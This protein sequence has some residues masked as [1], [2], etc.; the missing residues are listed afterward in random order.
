[1]QKFDRGR[2]IPFQAARRPALEHAVAEDDRRAAETVDAAVFER[3]FREKLE[4]LVADLADGDVAERALVEEVRGGRRLHSAPGHL[5]AIPPPE[6]RLRHGAVRELRGRDDGGRHDFGIGE[7]AFPDARGRAERER[8]LSVPVEIETCKREI[9]SAP[10]LSAA[11][12]NRAGV[13]VALE[14][15]V[16][17]AVA[18]FAHHSRR[19][20]LIV[21]HAGR[22]RARPEVYAALVALED[23]VMPRASKKA[24]VERVVLA[25][26]A[27]EC[28]VLHHVPA[29]LRVERA[30]RGGFAAV[31]EEVV[32]E[33]HVLH[34][35]RGVADAAA[36]VERA[37]FDGA[38]LGD[39]EACQREIVLPG[40]LRRHVDLREAEEHRVFRPRHDAILPQRLAAEEVLVLVV[41]ARRELPLA[42][43]DA[44]VAEVGRDLQ[45]VGLGRELDEIR[46][47]SPFLRRID[48][49]VLYVQ[50]ARQ[51]ASRAFQ[52]GH[53]LVV[54]LAHAVPAAIARDVLDRHVLDGAVERLAADAETRR[55]LG[56]RR[57]I[58]VVVLV[59]VALKRAVHEMG[60]VDVRERDHERPS[61]RKGVLL[62]CRAVEVE[63]HAV[64]DLDLA[65]RADA[66]G[67]GKEHDFA[68]SRRRLVVKKLLEAF[69]RRD[70]R[71][72]DGVRVVALVVDDL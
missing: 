62:Q 25:P 49:P 4:A 40:G 17:G 34:R 60:V 51:V 18:R 63:R 46:R 44:L 43:A 16:S 66:I 32:L 35:A 22:V 6:P 24:A 42:R 29:V 70:R 11:Q 71:L 14:A 19:V 47:E 50:S 68:E 54:E 9:P 48:S 31:R 52:E 5:D 26:V 36:A 28:H 45:P 13:D 58:L 23:E 37:V 72:L 59:V 8:C 61:S 57:R 30:F 64:G 3:A 7:A 41:P 39:E 69:G 53:L 65:E 21:A 27:A 20:H 1:M 56:I 2:R 12:R 15:A 10:A 38:V 67:S 33:E 55:P